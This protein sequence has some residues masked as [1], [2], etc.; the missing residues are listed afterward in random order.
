MVRAFAFTPL[1]EEQRNGRHCFMFRALPR[2][3]Y[4]AVSRETKVLKGMR[5]KMWIDAQQY[6][7]VRVSLSACSLRTSNRAPNSRS[8]RN[9]SP[10]TFGCRVTFRIA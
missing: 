9:P 6:Q 1:G 3:D 7:W 10:E 4:Q 5:G 2:P 8:K